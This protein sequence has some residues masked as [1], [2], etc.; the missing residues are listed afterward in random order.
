MIDKHDTISLF[1]NNS[2]RASC[3]TD[4]IWS[5][6]EKEIIF[7]IGFTNITTISIY[8]DNDSTIITATSDNNLLLTK[9]L[10]FYYNHVLTQMS[11]LCISLTV[12]FISSN[13]KKVNYDMCSFYYEENNKEDDGVVE[14]YCDAYYNIESYQ[15]FKSEITMQLSKELQYFIHRNI[16][17]SDI[18]TC[19]IARID[20]IYETANILSKVNNKSF[21]ESAKELLDNS[22]ICLEDYN[23]ICRIKKEVDNEFRRQETNNFK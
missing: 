2:L 4:Y 18:D 20:S 14:I 17:V 22:K 21:C 11:E 15:E 19:E 12:R 10:N 8:V 9:R 6:V 3:F 23:R 16:I 1:G 7:L 13:L 5:L